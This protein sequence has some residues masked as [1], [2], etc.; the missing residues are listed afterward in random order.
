[1]GEGAGCSSGK[2]NQRF[3]RE[4]AEELCARAEGRACQECR[5]EPGVSRQR[6]EWENEALGRRAVR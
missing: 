5:R 3:G 4:R 2:S 6:E 1:M